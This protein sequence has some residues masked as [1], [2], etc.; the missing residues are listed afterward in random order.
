MRG[1][2]LPG[3]GPALPGLGRG[4]PALSPVVGSRPLTARPKLPSGRRRGMAPSEEG[5]AW[6]GLSATHCSSLKCY[7]N[8]EVFSCHS[9]S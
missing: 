4:R 6:L 8:Q 1:R 3:P 2:A 7:N 9:N 5:S